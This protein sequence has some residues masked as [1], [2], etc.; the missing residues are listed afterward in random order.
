[1][2]S[3]SQS[4]DGLSLQDVPAAPLATPE[5]A[6][7]QKEEI[8]LIQKVASL[9]QKAWQLEEDKR[10]QQLT[11]KQLQEDN[12]KKNVVIGHW[13]SG[14]A[15]EQLLAKKGKLLTKQKQSTTAWLTGMGASVKQQ[16]INATLQK[17]VQD[18]IAENIVLN[19]KL[20]EAEQKLK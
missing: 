16:D 11:I 7:L 8:H 4:V 14:P 2:N 6:A 1:M 3:L 20:Q 18:T 17:V 5:L 19:E 9:T 15:A 12:D 13:L 10:N